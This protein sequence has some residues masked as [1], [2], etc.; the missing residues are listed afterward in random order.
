MTRWTLR[1]S[2]RS[3]WRRAGRR[4]RGRLRSTVGGGDAAHR[5]ARLGSGPNLTFAQQPQAQIGPYLQLGFGLMHQCS[6]GGPALTAVSVTDGSRLRGHLCILIGH[7]RKLQYRTVLIERFGTLGGCPTVGRCAHI[8]NRFLDDHGVR[9]ID[10]I[11]YELMD[12][13]A[14]EGGT[15]FPTLEETIHGKTVPPVHIL[16]DPEILSIVLLELI[17]EA[18]EIIVTAAR[19]E[20]AAMTAPVSVAVLS[21]EDMSVRN[22]VH[23]D[24]ALRTVSGVHLQGNQINIRGSSGFAYNTGSRVLMLLDG[25]PLLTPDSDGVP[26]DALPFAQIE[27]VEVLKGPGSALYGSGALGGV[28]NVIT[29]DYPDRAETSIRTFAG[30]YEPVRYKIWRAAWPGAD[31]PR[32]F[33]GAMLSHAR[34]TSDR[35]GFWLNLAWQNDQGY[36]NYNRTKTFHGYGKVG[37]RPSPKDRLDVLIGV[38][39]REKDSFLFW[40]GA[41]DALNPGSLDIGDS[42]GAPGPY[43]TPTGTNDNLN[44]QIS[45]LPAYTRLI[46]DHLYYSIRGRFFGTVIQPIDNVTGKPRS[47]SKGTLGFRYGGEIQLNWEE[48]RG[49][50]LTFGFTGDALA[51]RSSFFVTSDE[52]DFGSQPETAAFVQWEETISDRLQLVS[53]FRFDAYRIDSDRNETKLSPKISAA[54]SLNRNVTFRAAFGDG[55]RVPS[56]AER[57]TDNKDFFPI[58]RNLGLKPERLDTDF[59]RFVSD[60][61]L[62]VDTRVLDVRAGLTLKRFRASVLVNNATEYYYLER[63]ALLGPPRRLTIQLQIDF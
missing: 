34:R 30:V 6:D 19:R 27:R 41:R 37:W 12:R 32:F 13:V 63:P 48:R 55:F 61:D 38:M 10:G 46:S 5:L 31:D 50:L 9:V 22:I 60:A 56:F 53:G 39:A 59:S 35:F 11:P 7:Q 44:N 3:T 58:V 15:R 45:L 2:V 8:V 49:R 47:V 54:Y 17:F 28:V 4:V 52:N 23:L 42:S 25:M 29:R 18:D 24:D 36:M 51:T 57:F 33:S 16:V 43:D 1:T 40:N 26:F 14:K 21:A 62:L 20:Q